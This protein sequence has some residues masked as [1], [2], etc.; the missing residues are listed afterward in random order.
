MTSK[1]A[2][3]AGKSLLMSITQLCNLMLAG[4]VNALICPILYGASLCA[5]KKK[6]GGFRPIAVGNVFRRLTAKLAC[7]VVREDVGNYFRPPQVGFAT[8]HGC[9]A[10]IHAVRTFANAPKNVGKVLLKI[11]YKNA[12]NSVERDIMLQ[13]VS[14]KTLSLFPFLWQCYSSST[15]LLFGN[16]VIPSL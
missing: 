6:D 12:F 16:Q 8:Q 13:K 5:L 10:A 1:S 9:E 11:D 15:D 7:H 4:K 2:S 3:D 14:T